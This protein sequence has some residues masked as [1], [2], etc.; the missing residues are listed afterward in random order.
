[1]FNGQPSTTRQKQPDELNKAM[2]LDI[3]LMA[4][5]AA[6]ILLRLR[7]EL[8]KKTGNEPLPPAAGRNPMGHAARTIDGHAE[9]ADDVKVI[10]MEEDPKLRHAYADIRR[11][12]SSF[13][14][15][16]FLGGAQG[17]YRMILEAFWEGDR[18]T[19]EGMLDKSVFGQFD[20]AIEGRE[21]NELTLENRL[22][23]IS[24]ADVIAAE[25]D[26]SVAELTVH[27][28]SEIVAVTRDKNG[29]IVEGDASDAVETNDKWT[30]A[31]D[32]KSDDYSWTLI[33][34]RAG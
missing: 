26:G 15:A 10:D 27:F 1:M 12:D 34:T 17:A 14:P 23:D 18:E 6:F 8:G 21:T 30:F 3:I 25:L 24:E 13:D 22:I 32:L 2:F 9:P 16:Q 29:N 31:R 20:T 4:A 28:K 19:L 33:A 5:I 11:M 7:S